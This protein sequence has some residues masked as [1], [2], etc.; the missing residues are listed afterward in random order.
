MASSFRTPTS[1]TMPHS[2]SRNTNNRM[3]EY[4]FA[5]LKRPN[6]G[7]SMCRTKLC[8]NGLM[9]MIDRQALCGIWRGSPEHIWT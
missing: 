1:T 3:L 4:C 5:I 2:S 6:T 7:V 9:L 8:G